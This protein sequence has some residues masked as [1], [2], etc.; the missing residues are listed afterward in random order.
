MAL[1]LF[2]LALAPLLVLFFAA[3]RLADV[4]AAVGDQLGNLPQSSAAPL[5]YAVP[6]AAWGWRSPR[7]PRAVR[8]RPARSSP[9]SWCG[10]VGE[11]LAEAGRGVR[12]VAPLLNPLIL[13]TA[14]RLAVGK[15]F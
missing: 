6:L 2:I 4:A 7:S 12:R 9:S 15:R 13:S 1:A 10:V 11:V 8:M 3:P 5:I 14:P